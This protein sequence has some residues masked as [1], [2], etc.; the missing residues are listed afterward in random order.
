M[1]VKTLLERL[2]RQ[3]FFDDQIVH[4]QKLPMRPPVY[5]DV[6]G[7]LHEAV[8]AALARKKRKKIN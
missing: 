5:Q 8:Q 6:E 7:G 1:E 4:V 2:A 3:R